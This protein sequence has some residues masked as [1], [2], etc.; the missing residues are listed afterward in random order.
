MKNIS[1][2][3]TGLVLFTACSKTIKDVRTEYI[4]PQTESE[5]SELKSSSK[6]TELLKK[7][8][9]GKSPNLAL[10]EILAKTLPAEQIK[11]IK[12]S[13][14]SITSE[15]AQNILQT[16]LKDNFNIRQNYLFHQQNYQNND[17]FLENSLYNP[18]KL[19]DAQFSSAN[20][21]KVSV[22]TYM[23]NKAL[24]E[25]IATYTARANDLAKDLA[26]QIALEMPEEINK[27]YKT[28]SLEDFVQKMQKSEKYVRLIDKYFR[29]SQLSENEQYL[30]LASG[31]VAGVMYQ[32]IKDHQGVVQFIEEAKKV[33]KDIQVLKKKGS[34]FLVLAGTLDKH[35]TE[36]GKNIKDLKSGLEGLES[37]LLTAYREVK[38]TKPNNIHSRRMVTFLYDNVIRGKN[39][40]DGNNSSIFSK[41]V[42]IGE[43]VTKTVTAAA[44]ISS[45]LANIINV[46]NQMADTLGIKLSDN[47]LKIIDKANKVAA[48]A[49]AATAAIQGFSQ[50]GVV[51]A[52]SALAA[53]NFGG[54]SGAFGGGQ[55]NNGAQFALINMKLDKILDNQKIIMERQVET[56]KMIKDLAVM[57]DDYHQKEMALLAQLRDLSLV[58]LEM[59]KSQLNKDI[60]HC[61]RLINYQLS[62]VWKD[63]DFRV[64]SNL[65]I[66]N[67]DL[68]KTKFLSNIRNLGDIR[69][70]L[71]AGGV[72][73]FSH[74]QDALTEAFG[75]ELGS[76][77]PVLAI[78]ATSEDNRLYEWQ[79]D[80]YRPLLSALGTFA[81]T[82][83]FDPI[84]LHIPSANLDGLKIK[85]E[86]VNNAFDSGKYSSTIYSMDHLVSIQSLE[87][88]LTHLLIL[89]PLF[90]VDKGV[91]NKS[92]EEIINTYITSTNSEHQLNIRGHYYLSNALK[93]VQSAIAQESLLAGEPILFNL[94][95]SYSKEI[96]SSSPCSEETCMIR[97]NKLLMKNLTMLA[98]TQQQRQLPNFMGQYELAYHSD[99]LAA[100]AKLFNHNIDPAR[101]KK[102]DDNIQLDAKY[103]L[104][105]PKELQEK[106]IIYSENMPRLLK[107]QTMVLEALEKVSPYNREMETDDNLKLFFIGA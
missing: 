28:N 46:T 86:I 66:H 98:L 13:L 50:G 7:L 106:Q 55:D 101:L 100:L 107:M 87:R 64:D 12:K 103:N 77:N 105:T 80:T 58:N 65:G 20:M 1:F 34:E 62:S 93:M 32:L 95:N 31:S 43:N 6:D 10:A 89:Y 35:I 56:M 69:R 26:G 99:N 75:D 61:E 39:T 82:T 91:W 90:E 79:R 42:E 73:S 15:E 51:G 2:L 45:N 67:V 70:I 68:V 49:K 74:C 60:R 83:D 21:V 23:K 33:V 76:E 97:N 3:L 78:F 59:Q 24:E 92:L 102:V 29:N 19:A 18:D 38:F 96:F 8:L 47:T 41:K 22:L 94:Y 40:S 53:T 48:V 27:A 17:L 37:D 36:T 14:D 72:N 88:Y 104:P 25:I 85:S 11:E 5:G 30:L 52:V 63:Q 71:E 44:N 4:L 81:Q 16:A 84:P 9:N 54:M 57:I